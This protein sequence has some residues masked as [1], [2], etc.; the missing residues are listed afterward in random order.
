MALSALSP[1]FVPNLLSLCLGRVSSRCADAWQFL[2]QGVV[3]SCTWLLFC[4]GSRVDI[5]V[6]LLSLCWAF[7]GNV[8]DVWK[9]SGFVFFRIA[10]FFVSTISVAYMNIALDETKYI[11]IHFEK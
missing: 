5:S 6:I 9:C 2:V 7:N 3:P 8:D 1:G 11:L 10:S 4:L